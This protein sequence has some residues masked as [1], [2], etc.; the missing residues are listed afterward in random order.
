MPDAATGAFAGSRS[1]T[2]AEIRVVIADDNEGVRAVLSDLI[3]LQPGM[4]LV[5]VA[6]DAESAI[7]AAKEELPDVVV[8][9]VRMPGADGVE[10]MH[11]IRDVSPH[12]KVIAFTGEKWM[13]EELVA[14]GATSYLL[15]GDSI[16]A[17]TQ[18]IEQACRS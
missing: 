15:K 1:G 6:V 5:A 3:S 8:L 7:A 18:A 10:A 13:A 14:A 9:D 11:R 4:R 12:T 17:V 2:V 16:A